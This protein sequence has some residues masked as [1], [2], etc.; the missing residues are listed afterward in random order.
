M[1]NGN[2][3]HITVELMVNFQHAMGIVNE[4]GCVDVKG[5]GKLE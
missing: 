1:S 4:R 3:S 2:H 5:E